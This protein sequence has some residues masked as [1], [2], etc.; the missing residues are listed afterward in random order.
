MDRGPRMRPPRFDGR[1]SRGQRRGEQEGQDEVGH[2]PSVGCPACRSPPAS[3]SRCS[4]ARRATATDR[5]PPRSPTSTSPTGSGPFPVAVVLHGG[6]WQPRYGK[7]TTRP[8]SADLARR[9]WAAWNVEYRRL[10]A[11][12]GGWPAT[13][14]DVA[15]AIDHLATLGDARLDLGR[16]A[17]VGHSAGGQLALWAA[18]RPG[19]PAGA[20]GAEPAV[21]ARRVIG[22]APV[23]D[24]VRAGATARALLGGTPEQAPDRWAQADPLQRVP[25]SVPVVLVHPADDETVPVQRSRDYA[26][27]ARA[28]G[29][30]GRAD[31]AGDGRPP[32]ADRPGRRG[33]ARG[34][35]A[36]RGRLA[37]AGAARRRRCRRSARPPG[38][39]RA[40]R[41][42]PPRP[43][44]ATGRRAGRGPRAA[45][46][47]RSARPRRPR[48]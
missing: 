9:G 21:V 10:G 33:L 15:A 25:L 29:G 46:A 44:R 38:S 45:A 6:S 13:F 18:A 3:C 24:L 7:I 1:S 31:R 23:T 28:A 26:A 5:T 37:V 32:R 17:L 8:L 36:P 22:L 12:G 11:E 2:G 30:D 48:R 14:D 39:P 27:A 19:L 47:R 41:R 40:P 42:A 43:R 4:A 20:P 34:G 35:R 16:V